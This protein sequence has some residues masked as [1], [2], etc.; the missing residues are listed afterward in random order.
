MLHEKSV[1]KVT[2]ELHH[3]NLVLTIKKTLESLL[4]TMC[5]NVNLRDK[6]NE[7]II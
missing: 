7:L 3:S 2:D 5:C 6:T 4:K 1:M